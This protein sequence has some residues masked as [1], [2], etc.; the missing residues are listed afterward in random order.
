MFEN[1]F[2]QYWF[3]VCPEIGIDEHF[4]NIFLNIF[5][6]PYQANLGNPRYIARY[7]GLRI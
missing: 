5:N 7:I 3:K 1:K 4:S 2:Y 6:T